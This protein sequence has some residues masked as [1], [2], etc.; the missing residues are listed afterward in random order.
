MVEHYGNKNYF[1]CDGALKSQATSSLSDYLDSS[2]SEVKPRGVG[3][4]TVEV[5]PA[6]VRGNPYQFLFTHRSA[7]EN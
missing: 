6:P 4:E 7:I 1:H 5:V 2:N 3:Q